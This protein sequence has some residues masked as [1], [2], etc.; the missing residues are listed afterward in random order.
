[1]E[2]P[3]Q[4]IERVKRDFRSRCDTDILRE[5]ESLPVLPDEDSD[6]WDAGSQWWQTAERFTALADLA[7][8]R[9]L[10]PAIPLLFGRSCY[11]D[12]GEMMR[13]LRHA[14][15]AIVAPDYDEL[16]PFC[17]EAAAS[18]QPG[19]R[20][21]AVDE[22]GLLRD[23]RGLPALLA[24]LRDSAAEVRRAGCRSLSMLTRDHPDLR[25]EIVAALAT[26]RDSAADPRDWKDA[27]SAIQRIVAS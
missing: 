19:S 12:P 23:R 1:M 9:R 17:V 5:L 8:E 10:R 24:A 26:F 13:G 20:L 25:S 15:E 7:A 27:E 3:A 14:L 6:A 4:A 22:L 21:W 11:G 16:T 2:T 18:L